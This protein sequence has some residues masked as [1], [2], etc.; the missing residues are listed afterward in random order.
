MAKALWQKKQLAWPELSLGDIQGLCLRRWTG[1]RGQR[2]RHAERFWKIL[3]SESAF[4][5]WKLRCE[6][7]IGHAD[8]DD[9]EHTGQAIR[10]RWTRAMNERLHLDMVQTHRRFGRSAVKKDKVLGTWNGT[11]F[12]ELALPEDWTTYNRVLVGIDATRLDI[13]DDG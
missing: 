13:R 10:A 9:W 8:E 4:L 11:L 3:I 1:A 7:V 12:D 5:I 6:R 2:R